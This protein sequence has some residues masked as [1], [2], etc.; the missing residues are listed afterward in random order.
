MS[1]ENIENKSWVARHKKGI[2]IALSV[3]ATV[4]AG[5]GIYLLSSSGRLE[6]MLSS[7]KNKLL[8]LF[9]KKVTSAETLIECTHIETESVETISKKIVEINKQI[10]EKRPYTPPEDPISVSGCLVKLPP[11]HHPSPEK[12]EIGRQM[13]LDFEALGIT[14]RNPYMKGAA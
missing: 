1:K 12:I 11:N 13:G 4:A 3:G 10:I 6:P 5:V 9:S 2:V 8:P 14:W 7:A